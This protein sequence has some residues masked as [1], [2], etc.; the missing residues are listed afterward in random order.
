MCSKV[1]DREQF[2]ITVRSVACAIFFH[3]VLHLQKI[4]KFIFWEGY[5]KACSRKIWMWSLSS[6]TTKKKKE[7]FKNFVL[8]QFFFKILFFLWNSLI[9]LYNIYF[10]HQNWSSRFQEKPNLNFSFPLHNSQK[11]EFLGVY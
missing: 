5:S 9:S 6:I 10:F 3:T 4:R 8:L 7:K 1:C 11:N 2:T